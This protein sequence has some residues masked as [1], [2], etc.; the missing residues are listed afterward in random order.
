M[1]EKFRR[2]LYALVL[3]VTLAACSATGLLGALTPGKPAVGVEAQVGKENTKQAVGKQ[4]QLDASG[5][6]GQLD[7]SRSSTKLGNVQA[8]EF[9]VQQ[10]PFWVLGILALGWFL[11]GPKESIALLGDLIRTIKGALTGRKQRG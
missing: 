8:D 5:N 2:V 6:T 1:R 11:P 4:E 7:A 3:S 9:T 10:V